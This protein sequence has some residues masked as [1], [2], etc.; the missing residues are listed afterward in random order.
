MGGRC[1]WV[2]RPREP[3]LFTP[4][5]Q[6]LLADISVGPKPEPDSTD[7]CSP[8]KM[9]DVARLWAT[10][11]EMSNLGAIAQRL[12]SRTKQARIVCEMPPRD[13]EAV[14]EIRGGPRGGSV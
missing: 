14:W 6:K 5:Q 12:L 10:G 8:S 4:E 2:G 13:G 1:R 7:R 9:I 11:I 3:I